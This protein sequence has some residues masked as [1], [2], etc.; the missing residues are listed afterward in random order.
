MAAPTAPVEAQR[1]EVQDVVH[2][3]F[4]ALADRDCPR[5]ESLVSGR[6]RE[7]L[8]HGGG[9]AQV[10]RDEPDSFDI[11]FVRM[12]APRRDGRAPGAWMVRILTRHEGTEQPLDARVEWQGDG[13]RLVNM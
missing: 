5:L 12:E 2:G 10:L 7:R 6:A 13:F 3:V 8:L 11:E 9:C 1:A 4:A